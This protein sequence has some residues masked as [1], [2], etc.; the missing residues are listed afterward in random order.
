LWFDDLDVVSVGIEERTR[1]S[2]PGGTRGALQPAV[3]LVAG[4]ERG[5]WNAR[6]VASSPAGKSEVDMLGERPIVVDH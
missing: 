6:T 1:R 5:A 4:G 3:V 2:S